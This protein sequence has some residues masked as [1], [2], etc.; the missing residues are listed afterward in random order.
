MNEII[1]VEGKID[2]NVIE[3]KIFN[4]N[5]LVVSFDFDSHK[6]LN[7]NKIKHKLVEDYF[8]E[9]DK[10]EIDSFSLKLGTSW[11][12]NEKI[13]QYLEYD[14]INLG[15][16]LEL[17]M[18]SY[19]LKI[20]KRVIGIKKIVEKEEPKKIISYSLKKYVNEFCKK[21]EI[22]IKNY[23]KRKETGLFFDEISIPLSLGVTTKNIKISRKNYFRLKK[24]ME[25]ISNS[26]WRTKLNKKLLLN[27]ESILLIDFNTKLYEDLLKSFPVSNKNIIILNQ[28]KPAIWNLETL[29]IIKN[30]NCKILSIKDFENKITKEKNELDQ[31]EFNKKLKKMLND[32]NSLNAIFSHNQESFWEII[33][34]E[35]SDI[36]TK[37]FSESIKRLV[38]I[39]IMF[40]EMN[41]KSVLDW[42]HTGMEEKEIS[43]LANKRKI[44][45]FCLQ[46]G[47]MTLNP[48]FNK[49]HSIMPVLPSNNSKMLVWGEIMKDY[50]L[51]QNVNS[52]DI[53][54]VGSPRHDKF[55]KQKSN[56]N[57]NTILIASN[58][59]FHVNF[60]GNDTRA[61]ERFES[62]LKETLQYIKKN[63]NKKPIIKLHATEYFDIKPI[64][65]KVDPSIPVYQHEDILKLLKSCDVLISLNYSTILLDALILNKPSLVF[66]PE[67]QN[68]EQEEIIK[69]KAVLSVSNNSELKNQMEKILFNEDVRNDLIKN[70]KLFIEK[71]FSF[72]GN[73]CEILKNKLLDK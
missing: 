58:L 55:F 2:F 37:R 8:S 39:D 5:S 18:P 51:K 1:L 60:D 29:Q 21:K 38:L 65:K 69:Q 33:E 10:I 11:Y 47:I 71:Y 72:Q 24:I 4:N 25:K 3:K 43:F 73:S 19:F 41:I 14:K 44:P 50:L 30:S 9:E 32:K 15:S 20:L 64:I 35:F 48:K 22:T 54:I 27:N 70:G 66:L 68:F 17:E 36:I 16:L 40:N 45:I 53:T 52:K 57:N 26:I 63:S 62:F 34:N 13:S 42:A 56:E 6:T 12:K 49:Y 46:H 23:E 28:R 7:Q 61:I 67:K 31:K 59:F